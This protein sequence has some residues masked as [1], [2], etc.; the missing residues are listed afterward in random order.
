MPHPT[1]GYLGLGLMGMPMTLNLL[2]AGHTVHV[3]NRSAAKLKPAL[4][5]GAIACASAQEVADHA[6][7][8]LMCL[9]DTQAVEEVVFGPQG[10]ASGKRFKTLV[11]HASIRPD[12]T[13]EF[14]VRLKQ[15]CGA[16]WVD[17]PVSGGV[18][19][20][21]AG[22]LAI[23]CGGDEAAVERVR[24]VLAAYSPNIT[25][26]GPAGAGQTTK[27]CNQML[28]GCS[29]A[30]IAEVV[31]MAQSA[32]IDAGSLPKALGGGWADSK[33]MQTFV[34]RMVNG[35]DKPM[36]TS[37]TFLKDLETALALARSVDSPTPMTALA[38]QIFRMADALGWGAD[39]PAKL[40]ELYRKR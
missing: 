40:P 1:L 30:T 27:L 24:P 20:A 22:T 35:W 10:V 3:W 21:T 25:R 33:P 8:V 36:A 4:D 18:G 6:D 19:G 38:A 14:A 29:I 13:R 12:A 39:D 11:D 26:M 15:A 32:G 2:K 37:G 17:A 5:H 9:F 28:V 31:R 23:M 34:P 16:D 7:I